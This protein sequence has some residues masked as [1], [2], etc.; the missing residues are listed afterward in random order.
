MKTKTAK[1]IWHVDRVEIRGGA[2]GRGKVIFSYPYDARSESSV[3]DAEEW[4][5]TRAL[6]LKV[7]RNTEVLGM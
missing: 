4:L 2:Q 6:V 1:A 7:C 3:E 5:S